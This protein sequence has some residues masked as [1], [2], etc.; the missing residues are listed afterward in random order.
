MSTE[1]LQT[2][3]ERIDAWVRESR[4]SQGLCILEELEMRADEWCALEGYQWPFVEL[5]EGEITMAPSPS[6]N[7]QDTVFELAVLLRAHVRASVKGII[8]LSPLDLRL[9]DSTVVQ[10]DIMCF[11][12]AGDALPALVVE[13]LSPSTFRHDLGPKMLLYAEAGIAHYWVAD[14]MRK[15]IE[16]YEFQDG[17]YVEVGEVKAGVFQGPPFPELS[18]PLAELFPG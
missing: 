12:N 6:E 10:P 17:R 3:A 4:P 13:V 9:S 18:I 2:L 8:R 11:A 15:D 7:H 14:P 16:A 1:T 5:I